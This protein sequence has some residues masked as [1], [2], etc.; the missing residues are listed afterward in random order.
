MILYITREAFTVS[1]KITR[2]VA[3]LHK[4]YSTEEQ[5]KENKAKACRLMKIMK[6]INVN[7]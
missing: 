1:E 4:T 3:T 7:I 2:H 6:N 5:G